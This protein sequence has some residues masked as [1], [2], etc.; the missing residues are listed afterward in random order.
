MKGKRGEGAGH[1]D[2]CGRVKRQLNF[3]VAQD[4]D[5]PEKTPVL[6]EGK[7]LKTANQSERDPNPPTSYSLGMETDF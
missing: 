2:L 4:I 1:S 6:K 5:E 7:C 3:K